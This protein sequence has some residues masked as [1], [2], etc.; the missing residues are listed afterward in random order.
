MPA[1]EQAGC[2]KQG[3]LSPRDLGTWVWVSCQGLA[4][5]MV[6][7]ENLP[8]GLTPFFFCSAWHRL[9]VGFHY[10]PRLCQE[11]GFSGTHLWPQPVPGELMWG[12]AGA[13]DWM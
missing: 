3:P 2:G 11:P 10:I 1:A 4:S 8:S 13:P 6:L 5:S 9:L 7:A 12:Q